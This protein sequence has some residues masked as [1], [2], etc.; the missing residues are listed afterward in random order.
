MFRSKGKIGEIS[1][2]IIKIITLIYFKTKF[3]GY[4][5]VCRKAYVETIDSL[6]GRKI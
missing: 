4:L 6:K 1:K 2:R 3:D 5:D